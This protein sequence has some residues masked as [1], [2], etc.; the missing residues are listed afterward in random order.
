[1]IKIENHRAR[2]YHKAKGEYKYHELFRDEDGVVYAGIG[3]GKGGLSY[4]KLYKS[5]ATSNKN[6]LCDKIESTNNEPSLIKADN[7]GRYTYIGAKE[8]A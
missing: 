3:G 1:M 2:L 7:L 6:T 8:L 4:I 5:K